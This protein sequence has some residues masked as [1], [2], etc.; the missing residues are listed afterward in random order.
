[1]SVTTTASNVSSGK[2][3]FRELTES[4][5]RKKIYDDVKGRSNKG[6]ITMKTNIGDI[7]F[8][9]HCDLVPITGENF[10]ELAEKKYYKNMKFHR[11]VRD[12]MLQGGD[13]T[14]TGRGG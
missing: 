5:I 2:T 9:I 14:G 12:F 13:P 1:M 11:L 4:E 10:L 7:N 3:E 8:K 6:Y